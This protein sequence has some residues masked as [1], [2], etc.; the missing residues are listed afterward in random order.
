MDI[1]TRLSGF[2][3]IFK[4]DGW[5]NLLTGLGVTGRDKRLGAS[6]KWNKLTERQVEELHDCDDIAHRVVNIIP[7]TGTEKWIE[8]SVADNKD[9]ANQ[10]KKEDE[11]LCVKDKVAKAWAWARLYGGA[12]IFIN[13]QDGLDPSEPLDVNRILKIRSLN[14]FHRYELFCEQLDRDINSENYG[15][16]LFYTVGSRNGNGYIY[17]VHYTRILRFDGSSLSR[18]SFDRNDYWDDSVLTKMINALRNFNLAHDSVTSVLQDF[19]VGILKLKNLADIIGGDDEKLVVSRLKLMNLSKSVM[20]SI[21]L[22]SENETYENLSTP[23]TNIDKVLDKVNERLV[24]A[25]DLPHTII[26]GNGATGTLSGGGESEERN[27]KKIVSSQ[28][29]KVLTKNLNRFYPIMLAQRQGPTKGKVPELFSWKY[30]A[31]WV[32]TEKEIVEMRN[33]Q[34]QTDKVYLDGMVLSPIDVAKNRFGGEEY[35][36]ETRVDVDE[37]MIPEND[38]TDPEKA[39]KVENE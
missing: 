20:G 4:K 5:E 16:P 37:M 13:V 10:I 35:S 2:K 15:F 27:F 1:G 7:E 6:A 9:V 38:D 28:Q 22:D 25:T 21:L 36:Y 26:L 11:R 39:N 24:A 34:A 19:N 18:G 33:K 32:P 31:L 3:N 14:V 23:L 8:L 17:R 30:N 29:D 12:G